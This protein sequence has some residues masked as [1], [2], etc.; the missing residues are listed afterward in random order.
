MGA[1]DFRIDTVAG[2][3]N[4]VLCKKYMI[5]IVNGIGNFVFGLA[6]ASVYG[7]GRNRKRKFVMPL[8]HICNRV[9]GKGWKNAR[10]NQ[11]NRTGL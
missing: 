2:E 7:F 10:F 5:L 1:E 3:K 11:C 6:K 8:L 4:H 9:K